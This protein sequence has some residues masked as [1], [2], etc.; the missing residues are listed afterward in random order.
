MSVTKFNIDNKIA[1]V[2]TIETRSPPMF[3][4]LLYNTRPHRSMPPI[5]TYLATG[6]C[7]VESVEVRWL[8]GLLL[9]SMEESDRRLG[10]NFTRGFEY[11]DVEG[12]IYRSPTQRKTR[13]SVSTLHRTNIILKSI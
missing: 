7:D 8:A 3:S 6:A 2:S 5:E 4:K 10:Y 12:K 9:D 11:N 13:V 1:P